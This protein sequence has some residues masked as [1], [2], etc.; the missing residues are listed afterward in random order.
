V[1]IGSA[2]KKKESGTAR[3]VFLHRA[4]HLI[5][6]G[7]TNGVGGADQGAIPKVDSSGVRSMAGALFDLGRDEPLNL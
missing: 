1:G 7:D 5:A 3:R 4:R 2:Q 6:R